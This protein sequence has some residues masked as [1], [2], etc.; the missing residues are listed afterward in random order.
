MLIYPP[1]EGRPGQFLRL[2]F[3]LPQTGFWIDADAVLVREA[4]EQATYAWGLRFLLLAPQ[5]ETEIERYVESVSPRSSRLSGLFDSV[6]DPGTRGTGYCM[7]PGTREVVESLG[8]S[9]AM[10]RPRARPGAGSPRPGPSSPSSET[11]PRVPPR[12]ESNPRVVP[13]IGSGSS[14]AVGSGSSARIGSGSS[15]AVGRGSSA[16]IGSG[17]SARIGSGSSPAVGSGA[18]RGTGTINGPAV[19]PLPQKGTGSEAPRPRRDPKTGRLIVEPD[20]VVESQRQQF[21]DDATP[22]Q[23]L[24]R[25]A[26]REIEGKKDKKGK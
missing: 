20:P 4:A 24:Y 10:A 21:L 23:E 13:R 2:V 7:R 6:D 12:T 11:N 17:S 8:G 1:A 5:A 26:I 3:V 14:P 16:R 22:I 25:Q 18:K 15:P 9:R 19:G